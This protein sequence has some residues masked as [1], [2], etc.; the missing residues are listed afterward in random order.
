MD[1]ASRLAAA[2]AAGAASSDAELASLVQSVGRRRPPE[3]AR[4]TLVARDQPEIGP[5]TP[6]QRH[7]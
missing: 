1:L 6:L 4:E 5:A 3:K 2:A 7:T